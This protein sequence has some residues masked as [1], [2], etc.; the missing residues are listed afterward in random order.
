MPPYHREG[1]VYLCNSDSDGYFP[2]LECLCIIVK[3]LS[4][5]VTVILMA[6]SQ[7]WTASVS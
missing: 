4:T 3:V 5:Y 1:F 7:N 6:I 2:E